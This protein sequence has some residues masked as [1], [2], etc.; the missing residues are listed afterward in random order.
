[1]V[2]EQGILAIALCLDFGICVDLENDFPHLAE[3]G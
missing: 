3:I 1:M 2:A